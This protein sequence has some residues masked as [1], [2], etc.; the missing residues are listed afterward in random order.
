MMNISNFRVLEIF[1]KKVC[2]NLLSM[3][4][5]ELLNNVLN[6]IR[7]SLKVRVLE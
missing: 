3:I 4:L 2:G 1:E 6:Y 7:L 5:L